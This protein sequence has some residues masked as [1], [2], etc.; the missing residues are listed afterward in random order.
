MTCK[1]EG[2]SYGVGLGGWGKV[3]EKEVAFRKRLDQW[4]GPRLAGVQIKG[5]R[6]AWRGHLGCV[7]ENLKANWGLNSM[8]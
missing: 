6:K 5:K 3:S 4:E 7:I 8:W 2:W 1:F